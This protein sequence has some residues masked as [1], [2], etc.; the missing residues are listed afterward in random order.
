MKKITQPVLV[1]NG[2]NDAIMI[3]T[4]NSFTLSA[5]SPN[6]H[7]IIYPGPGHGSLFSMLA[8]LRVM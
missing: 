6:A 5:H 1:T 8:H 2:N 7:F 4:V 3:P